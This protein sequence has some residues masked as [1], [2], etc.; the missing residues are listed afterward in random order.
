MGFFLPLY[1]LCSSAFFLQQL[2]MPA[3]LMLTAIAYCLAGFSLRTVNT[4]GKILVFGA[5]G[6]CKSILPDSCIHG[7]CWSSAGMPGWELT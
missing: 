2:L 6:I 5:D 3:L 4:E 7:S 1:F